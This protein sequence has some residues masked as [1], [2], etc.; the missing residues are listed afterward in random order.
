MARHALTI[1]YQT[2]RRHIPE[3]YSFDIRTSN[4]L[5]LRNDWS[6]FSVDAVSVIRGKERLIQFIAQ[7]IYLSFSYDSYDQH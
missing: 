1:I 2:T 6:F 7:R 3:Y 5:D 4:K